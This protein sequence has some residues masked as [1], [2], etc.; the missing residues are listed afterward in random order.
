MGLDELRTASRGDRTRVGT[1][2]VTSPPPLGATPRLSIFNSN[3]S[4]GTPNRFNNGKV[5][6][7]NVSTDG[8]FGSF[9]IPE[10][11]YLIIRIYIYQ[12]IQLLL[13]F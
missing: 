13:F 2:S 11:Q 3:P 1:E 7:L 5:A 10:K 4:D 6:D 9:V 8:S 12:L